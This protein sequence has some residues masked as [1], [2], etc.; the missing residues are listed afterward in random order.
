MVEAKLLSS[1]NAAANSFKVS[2]VPGAESIR[3]DIAV[4]TKAVVAIC[5]VFV[6]LL[7]VGAVGMPSNAAFSKLS[8]VYVK[9]PEVELYARLLDDAGNPIDTPRSVSSIFLI[10]LAYVSIVVVEYTNNVV[11]STATPTLLFV[12]LEVV[13]NVPSELI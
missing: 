2:R 7:A 12:E 3:P 4:C 13:P 1:P 6:E 9:I 8:G 10:E 11:S 5:D